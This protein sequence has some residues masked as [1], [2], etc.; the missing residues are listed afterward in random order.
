MKDIINNNK[1][2]NTGTQLSDNLFITLSL[3]FKINA[4]N[5]RHFEEFINVEQALLKY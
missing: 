1:N 3:Y 4:I 2:T 5:Y